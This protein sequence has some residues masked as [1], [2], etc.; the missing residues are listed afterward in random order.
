MSTHSKELISIIVPNYNS[1][2]TIEDALTSVINQTYKNWEMII[3]DDY[4]TDN[5]IDVLKKF[6]QTDRRVKYIS[7]LRNSGIPA[8]PRN[9]GI[10]KAKGTFLAFLDSDDVW[11][12]QKLEL[13]IEFLTKREADFCFTD[14]F[15]FK[16]IRE[17]ENRIKELFKY[18]NILYST[19]SHSKLLYKNVISMSSVVLRSSIL[20]K[21]RFYEDVN[22]KAIEDYLFWLTIHQYKVDKSYWLKHYLVFYRLSDLSISKSKLAMLRKNY[23]VYSNYKVNGKSLGLRKYI[24]MSTYIFLSLL[25]LI[26]YLVVKRNGNG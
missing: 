17:I 5:S 6:S 2:K 18:E 20:D 24:Y 21:L 19:L 22:Y 4:S 12:P 9:K 14:V 1:S 13:Q 8:V 10:E 25:H 11:H 15:P 16:G 23:K 3:I 26:K 7:L